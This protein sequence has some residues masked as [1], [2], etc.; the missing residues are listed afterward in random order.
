MS[1]KVMHYGGMHRVIAMCGV[2]A[3]FDQLTSRLAEVTCKRCQRSDRYNED[4]WHDANVDALLDQ[5]DGQA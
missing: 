2:F 5:E 1:K 3:S 4:A